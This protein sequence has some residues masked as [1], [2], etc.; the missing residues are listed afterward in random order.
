MKKT[1]LALAILLTFVNSNG[2]ILEQSS[3][4]NITWKAYK[5]LAKLG[6][7]GD[8]T[9]FK[10]TPNAKEGKNFRELLVG[11]TVS[12]N[13]NKIDTNNKDR[14]E[15]ISK[16]FFQKLNSPIIEGKIVDMKADKRVSK[17]PRTGMLDIMITMNKQSIIIPMRYSYENEIFSAIGVIDIFDFNGKDALSTINKSCYDLHK[18]KTWSDVTIRFTTNIKAT[19]CIAK[20]EKSKLDSELNSE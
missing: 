19:L 10:Y 18:G 3:D 13:T 20:I 16:M 4:L 8:F 9:E 11:S 7:K 14:D 12:I 17:Q 1:I 6:V 2:C 5:T 15:T